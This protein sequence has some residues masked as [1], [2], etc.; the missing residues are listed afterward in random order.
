MLGTSMSHSD[1]S[2]QG[3]TVRYV[4]RHKRYDQRICN[5]CAVNPREQP[6]TLDLPAAPAAVTLPVWA[7][8]VGLL[9]AGCKSS[10]STL[11]ENHFYRCLGRWQLLA[12]IQ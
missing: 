2:L 12:C 11:A 8:S 9:A 4:A 3:H 1:M 6:G 7:H 5:L 10:S